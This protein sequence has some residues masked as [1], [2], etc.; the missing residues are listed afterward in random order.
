MTNTN[1]IKNFDNMKK[2]INKNYNTNKIKTNWKIKPKN[3]Q[4][5][6]LPA[7]KGEPL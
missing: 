5:S 7:G 4:E 3:I 1:S 6:G 2:S